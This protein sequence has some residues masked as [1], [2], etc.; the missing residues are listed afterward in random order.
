MKSIVLGGGCFWGVEAYFKQLPGV[1]DTEV[2]Y[3]NGIGE[4]NYKKVC[5]GSGH[6]EAV[7]LHYDEEI[8]SLKICFIFFS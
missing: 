6:A 8:I 5:Q 1:T 7:F 2:G 4:T 3:I